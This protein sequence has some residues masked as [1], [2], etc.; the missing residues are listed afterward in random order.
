M[1]K[2]ING[3]LFSTNYLYASIYS[4]LISLWPE[5]TAGPRLWEKG[6]GAGRD[7]LLHGAASRGEDMAVGE[8][9]RRLVQLLCTP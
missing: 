8:G 3:K 1:G 7:A 6:L 9:G 2:S 4:H 5:D